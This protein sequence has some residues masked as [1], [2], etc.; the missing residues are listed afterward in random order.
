MGLGVTRSPTVL[1]IF[2]AFSL[3]GLACDE[4]PAGPADGPPPGLVGTVLDATGAPVGNAPVGL[5]YGIDNGQA[6]WPPAEIGGAAPAPRETVTLRVT[7]A[8]PGEVRFLVWDFLYRTQRVL[9]DGAQL[10]AGDHQVEFDWTDDAGL[11]LPNGLYGTLLLLDGPGF[12]IDIQQTSGLLRNT[13]SLDFGTEIGALVTTDAGGGFRIPYAELPIGE[14][15]YCWD[16]QDGVC[17]IPDSLWVQS[18]SGGL[19][20]RRLLRLDDLDSDL[21]VTLRLAQPRD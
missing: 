18:A 7:L 8:E 9:L 10:A 2:V 15:A 3:A 16:G 11:P 14:W 4:D 19:A 20:A 12:S 13:L 21:P 6:G 17:T 5:I 1:A